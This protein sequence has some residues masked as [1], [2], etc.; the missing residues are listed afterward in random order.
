[1]VT[2]SEA[3]DVTGTPQIAL[4]I[5]KGKAQ[6]NYASG[7]GTTALVFSH[8]IVAADAGDVSIAANALALNEGSINAADTFKNPA[9]LTHSAV[10]TSEG[11]LVDSAAPAVTAVA[12]TSKVD[13]KDN[14]RTYVT[15]DE[16]TAELTFNEKVTVTGKP[17]L[18]L[19][20]WT[21]E[22][23]YHRTATYKS[24]TGTD[25]LVFSYTVTKTDSSN[26][27]QYV[28][29]GSNSLSE[30]TGTIQDAVGNDAV[31]AHAPST[32]QK[33]TVNP[34]T[35]SPRMRITTPSEAAANGDVVFTIDVDK[36]LGE[37]PNALQASDFTID[38]GTGVLAEVDPLP[39]G[40]TKIGSGT[41]AKDVVERYTLTVTPTQTSNVAV[42]VTLDPDSVADALGNAIT[43]VTATY[44]KTPPT[45]TITPPAAPDDDG[46][47]LFTFEFS[48]PLNNDGFPVSAIDRSGS[49]N[50][51]LRDGAP[52]LA[53]DSVPAT[54]TYE[55]LV[56][57]ADSTRDTTVLLLIGSVKDKAGNGL[58][59]D[60]QATYQVP[61]TNTPPVFVAWDAPGL[62]WCEGVTLGDT[63][64]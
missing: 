5:G 53:A 46:K 52:E 42:T 59:S 48:E 10:A 31:L 60:V 4:M 51:R 57:P 23:D 58:A 41:N 29:V 43:T 62:T 27:Y 2:F 34:D 30:G 55:L 25:T 45:V 3:V 1:M 18:I 56:T 6:A 9:V 26:Q 54:P 36:A 19:L 22:A 7:T 17:N 49:D 37:G 64:V 32:R 63:E 50:V 33:A 21:E 40:I 11:Q 24:G 15:G 16:I 47:L 12:I 39:K 44:D 35:T 14:E 13:D 61:V 20:L 28:Q 8:S 38:G